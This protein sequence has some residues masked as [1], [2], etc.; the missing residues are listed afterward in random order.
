MSDHHFDY[1]IAGAGAAGLSLALRFAQDEFSDKQVLLLDRS[2]KRENDRTWCFWEKQAGPFESAIFKQWSEVAFYGP[3]QPM[4][5]Q[6]APYTYKMLRG[7]DFYEFTLQKLQVSANVTVR[8]AEIYDLSN[9]ET[10]VEVNTS[11]GSFTADWAFSSLLDNEEIHAAKKS[12]FLWQHFLGWQVKTDKPVFNPAKPVYMDFRVPQTDGSCFVYV[13]PFSPFEA[14]VEYTVFSPEVW[15]KSHY[16]GGIRS[17]LKQY[18]ELSDYQTL[19][20]EQGRIPMSSHKFPV[21]NGK[22]VFVGTAG[23]QTKASTGYTFTNIQRHSEAIVDRLRSGKSPVVRKSLWESRYAKYDHTL[24][25]VLVQGEY[26]GA[27][28]FERLF[29]RNNAARMF[30]F[31]DDQSHFGQELLIMNSVP[32]LHFAQAFFKVLF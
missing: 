9:T 16:E 21:N 32:R 11:E 19:H 24:L 26:R 4:S 18:F 31:L 17:Y 29:M 1:I 6:M 3:Q 10:G 8:K 23:G 20:V 27:D 2:S 28:L 14:L 30:D 25:R 12:D 13:L 5:L 7:L 15:D 22:I